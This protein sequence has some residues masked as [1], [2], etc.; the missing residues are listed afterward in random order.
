MDSIRNT[1]QK[2]LSLVH[3]MQ[4]PR[5][6]PR[7][8]LLILLH[9]VGSNEHDLFDLAGLL[10]PRFLT[11]S[12]RSP[13]TFG[14]GAYGW[15]PVTFTPQGAVGDTR[16]AEEGRQKL[17]T[18]I[19]EAVDTYGADPRQVY[20]LGFSQGAIMSLAV[21]LTRPDLVAGAVVMSG[22]LL[23]EAFAHRADD[24]A[25]RG[26]P[27]LAVHGVLDTVLTIAEAREMNRKLS[28]LPLDLTYRE[29]GMGHHTTPESIS[30]VSRWLTARLDR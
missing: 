8:P 12:V 25:L 23:P 19:G 4:F 11:L 10:D 22:R 29:Y 14:P 13:I 9:G 7:P 16:L 5:Q 20:L 30:E 17:I 21:A 15:Y 24:A 26:L 3:L 18:F 6:S 27:I 1:P 2:P 28:T